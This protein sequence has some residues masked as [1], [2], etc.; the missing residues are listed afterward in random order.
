MEEADGLLHD[1]DVHAIAQI[2]DAGEADLLD[3]SA[4]EIFRESLHQENEKKGEGEDGPDV[5]DARRNEIVHIHDAIGAGNLEEDE[6]LQ[7]GLRIQHDVEGGL[8]CEGDQTFGDA[9]DGHE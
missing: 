7:C 4:A 2:G 8:D 6:F 3:Q 1:F 5:V 9:H